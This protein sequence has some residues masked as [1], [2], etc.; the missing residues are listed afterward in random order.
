[1][2]IS[3][4]LY[5]ILL[6]Y[7]FFCIFNYIICKV[8]RGDNPKFNTKYDVETTLIMTFFSLFATMFL[9]YTYTMHKYEIYQLRK[10]RNE[11]IKL[12]NEIEK[13]L[14]I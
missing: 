7:I 2:E 1:M 8:A 11:L 3:K 6:G 4:F 9:F 14:G 10:K 5:L 13:E 12:E